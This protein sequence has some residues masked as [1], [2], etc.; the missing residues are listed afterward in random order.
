MTSEEPRR[1]QGTGRVAGRVAIVTG[2]ARGQGA[3]EVRMFAAEGAKVVFGDILDDEGKALADD[4]GADVHYVHLDVTNEGDWAAAVQ[5]AVDLYGGLHVLVGNAGISLP[6]KMIADTPPEEYRRVIEVN[7]VGMFLGLHFCIPAI[8]ATGEGGS[9]ILTS[10]VNGFIGGAG[11]AGYAS[12]KFAIRGLAK[13]AA[14]EVARKG[15]R[16][17]SV[18]P[19]PIDTAMLDPAP[20]LTDYRGM[21]AKTMPLGRLGSTEEVAELVCWLASDASAYCTGSEFVIDGGFLAGP[22][23]GIRTDR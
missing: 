10:S 9:I 15:I 20:G 12:S 17:N 2:A 11:I 8:V 21:L 4:L 23:N 18:H 22:N 5:T 16:V 3:A 19:G 14:L 1:A 7:Q 6:V 13:T